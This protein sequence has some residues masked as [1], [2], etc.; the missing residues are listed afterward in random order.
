MGSIK[1]ISDGIKSESVLG[2]DMIIIGYLLI[3]V[4]AVLQQ[5][6]CRDLKIVFIDIMLIL[7]VWLVALSIKE[8]K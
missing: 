5:H 2:G 4:S 3:M 8:D 7:G 6:T 1:R